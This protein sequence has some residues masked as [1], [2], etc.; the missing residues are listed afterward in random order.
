M[1]LV[2]TSCVIDV[3]RRKR[4]SSVI[5]ITLVANFCVNAYTEVIQNYGAP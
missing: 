1:S 4:L 5:F 3:Y 2:Y